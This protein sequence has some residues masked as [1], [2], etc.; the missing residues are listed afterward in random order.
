MIEVGT[1]WKDNYNRV[2]KVIELRYTGNIVNRINLE[3]DNGNNYWAW[4]EEMTNKLPSTEDEYL[5]D[6]IE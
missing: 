5:L 1:Y 2:F 6:S 4:P 3:Y